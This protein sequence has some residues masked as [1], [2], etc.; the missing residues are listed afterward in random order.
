M[1]K[2]TGTPPREQQRR[3]FDFLPEFAHCIAHA[4]NSWAYLE[5]Y[6][7]VSIWALAGV[8]PAP[9]ACMTSQIYTINARLDSLVAL[10]K[11]RRVD[12]DLIKRVNKFQGNV[13]GAQDLRNRIVHDL[14]FNDSHAPNNMGKLRI[15]ASRDL[16]FGIDSITLE[17]MKTDL[18]RIEKQRIEA[19]AIRD[20][21]DAAIPALPEIPRHELHPILETP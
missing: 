13:R 19:S 9:G 17:T 3:E 6:I 7:N 2:G 21:I 4:A 10:M 11:L 18:L 1:A 16:K 8:A 20:A 15:T 12:D 5:Y 14:W